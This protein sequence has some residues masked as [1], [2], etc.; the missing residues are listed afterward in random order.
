ME[1]YPLKTRITHRKNHIALIIDQPIAPS[2]EGT[3]VLAAMTM[4][5]GTGCWFLIDIRLGP[6]PVAHQWSGSGTAEYFYSEMKPN[7]PS[8]ASAIKAM[9]KE[10]EEREDG[11]LIWCSFRNIVRGEVGVK[12]YVPPSYNNFHA[13]VYHSKS[14]GL[15]KL[16]EIQEFWA[17]HTGTVAEAQIENPY[18]QPTRSDIEREFIFQRVMKKHAVKDSEDDLSLG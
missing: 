13:P 5:E 14:E 1:Q 4:M 10:Y 8:E 7:T 9:L 18:A 17:Q 15:A 16:N 6:R 11:T 12:G 3:A 2:G